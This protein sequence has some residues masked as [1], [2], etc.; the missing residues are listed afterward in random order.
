[1]EQTSAPPPYHVAVIGGG[2][3]GLASALRLI[4]ISRETGRRCHV[5]IY[6]SSPRC[7]GLVETQRIGGYL[8]ERGAD[9]FITNKPGA[10]NLCRRLGLEQRLIGTDPSFRRSYIL[11]GGRPVE[12][13]EGL[14]LLAPTKLGPFLKSPLLSW[15][16]KLRAVAEMGLPRR[17]TGADESLA[18]FVRRRFGGEMLDRIVQPMVGGIYTSDPEKLSLRATLPR[19]L[20]ME[21][22][23]GSVIRALKK[24]ASPG[25]DASGA[26]YGLFATLPDGLQELLQAAMKAVQ[27]AGTVYFEEPARAVSQGPP[28]ATTARGPW[29]VRSPRSEQV[30]DAVIVALPA[31]RAA[32]LLNDFDADLAKELRQIEYASSAIVVSGHALADVAHPLAGAGLVIPHVEKRRIIAVSFASR[33][34]PGRAPEG[35][36]LLRTFVGGAMQPDMLN[37]SD[38]TMKQAVTDELA[39]LL[40]VRGTPDFM[41]VVRYDRG[42]PQYHVGHLDRVVRIDRQVTAQ[43]GLGLCGNAYR[44]VGLPDAAESGVD[45]ANKIWRD[46]EYSS[47][48][49]SSPTSSIAF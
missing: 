23:H 34:F 4:D 26:R 32:D 36:V 33:K 47:P 48:G 9:S 30:F 38:E 44:G 1:M 5:T 16:G 14:Q 3:S 22:Q 7:G 29:T 45:A 13:P 17:S 19:F 18:S 39:S 2:I 49:Y 15:S 41:E 21:E 8:V 28:S 43:V 42:M 31:F 24:A 10:I 6:E 20:E 46:L 37:L 40:G 27:E 12:C 25:D 11:R 35:R